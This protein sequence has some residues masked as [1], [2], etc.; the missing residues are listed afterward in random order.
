MQRKPTPNTKQDQTTKDHTTPHQVRLR[1]VHREKL[2]TMYV[3][4]VVVVV[5]LCFMAAGVPGGRELVLGGTS[6]FA[7]QKVGGRV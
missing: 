5:G 4:A 1:Y 6:Y 2:F 7:G 3:L